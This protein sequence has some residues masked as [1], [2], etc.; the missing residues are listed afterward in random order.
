MPL[1]APPPSL[2]GPGSAPRRPERSSGARPRAA[3]YAQCALALAS[4]SLKLWKSRSN[5]SWFRMQRCT[6]SSCP[7]SDSP[8]SMAVV[9]GGGETGGQGGY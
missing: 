9:C 8:P 3:P 4:S 1:S 5:Q 7:T 2:G 6:T